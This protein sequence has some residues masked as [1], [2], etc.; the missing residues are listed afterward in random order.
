MKFQVQ[1]T[2]LLKQLQVIGGIL[3]S[4]N[5]LPILDNFLFE[6][7]K[8]EVTVT[9][10]DLETTISTKIPVKADKK[11]VIAIPAKMLLDTLKTFP[12][13][14][15]VFDIDDKTFGIEISAGEGRYKLT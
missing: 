12:E 10:S 15:L 6:I 8:G 5:S 11:A 4:N 2:T 9:A 14:P 13:T 1:S 7:D 3:N